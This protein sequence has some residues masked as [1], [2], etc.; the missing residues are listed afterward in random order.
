MIPKVVFNKVGLFNPLFDPGAPIPH[1]GSHEMGYRIIKAGY[2]LFYDHE[3]K[4]L[5]EHPK[6]EKDLHRKIFTYCLGDTAL[7]SYFF[8]KYGDYRGIYS[9]FGGY[10]LDLLGKLTRACVGKYPLPSEY[11][12]TALIGSI[13]GPIILFVNSFN[14]LKLK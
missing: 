14:Y 1:G 2:D 11:V 4:V 3:A 13:F 12:L 8:F 5:H 10:Q 7:Y 6:T 9:A